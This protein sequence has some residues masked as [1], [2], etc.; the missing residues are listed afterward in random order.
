MK[1]LLMLVAAILIASTVFQFNDTPVPSR[2]LVA[3]LLGF[4]DEPWHIK[5][6]TPFTYLSFSEQTTSA[7]KLQSTIARFLTK[8]HVFSDLLGHVVSGG[9][10]ELSPGRSP[11]Y[12]L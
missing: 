3:A 4:S 8:D 11:I 6:G 7:D 5:E 1:V 10:Y 2:G 12:L 9:S